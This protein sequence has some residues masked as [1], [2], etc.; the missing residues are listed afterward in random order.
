[1]NTA[2]AMVWVGRYSGAFLEILSVCRVCSGENPENEKF[3]IYRAPGWQK[4]QDLEEEMR[5]PATCCT[6]L[7]NKEIKAFLLVKAVGK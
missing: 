7:R 3:R 6:P 4:S 2:A 5:N 1:M